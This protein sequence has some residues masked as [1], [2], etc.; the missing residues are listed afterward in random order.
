MRELGRDIG[1]GIA[2]Y[3]PET[4]ITAIVPMALAY[5]KSGSQEPDLAGEDSDGDSG[6]GGSGGEEELQG[7]GRQGSGGSQVL[8]RQLSSGS[9]VAAE[10]E[11]ESKDGVE[12][13]YTLEEDSSAEYNI[14][15]SDTQAVV[16]GMQ[17]KAVQGMLDFDFLCKRKTPSVAAIV[18]PF[19][20]NHLQKFYYGTEEIM[21]PV[22]QVT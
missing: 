20:G 10:E 8:S 1:V 5:A 21:V 19:S 17:L 11:R 18:F 4:H 22:I 6:S 9:S 7:L 3:G 15:G 2:V 13:P 12:L 14:M 16:Y